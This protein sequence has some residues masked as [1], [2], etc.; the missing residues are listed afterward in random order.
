MYYTEDSNGKFTN[1]RIAICIYNHDEIGEIRGIDA[2]QEMELSMLE[3]LEKKIE[4]MNFL[5][6][7]SKNESLMRIQRI[8]KLITLNKKIS[9]NET[10]T[11]EE[12]I[13]FFSSS[14]GFGR[15]RHYLFNSILLYLKNHKEL[16]SR[17]VLM[18][19]ARFSDA[20]LE[21]I[22]D[23]LLM[24][25]SFL[26][27][28]INQNVNVL[29]YISDE[30]KDNPNFMLKAIKINQMAIHH[31]SNKLK[32]KREFVMAASKRYSLVPKSENKKRFI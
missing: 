16:I 14:Y 32:G 13:E 29:R 10:I 25:E 11:D 22:P 27:D 21:C 9:N 20:V 8:K 26:L 18:K 1:P 12:L 19:T 4:E 5:K 15:K 28:I 23:G 24:D 6:S 30:L 7:S 3:P 17:E 2:S 31:I